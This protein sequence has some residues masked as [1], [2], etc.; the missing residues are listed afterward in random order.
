MTLRI[1]LLISLFFVGIGG[2]VGLA[3]YGKTD[4]DTLRG[5]TARMCQ[6]YHQRKADVQIRQET[7]KLLKAYRQCLQKY[8][9]NPTKAKENC[10]IYTH[11]LRE[12]ELKYREVR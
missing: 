11:A 3:Q 6:E 2:C 9:D 8:E 5:R 1:A 7:G 10:S 12:I 4:C